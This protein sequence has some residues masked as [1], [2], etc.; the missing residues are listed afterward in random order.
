MYYLSLFSVYQK[1]FVGVSIVENLKKKVNKYYKRLINCFL[2]LL[3]LLVI[4]PICGGMLEDLKDSSTDELIIFAISYGAILMLC[5][6]PAILI[7]RTVRRGKYTA[8][9]DEY[10]NSLDAVGKARLENELQQDY[11]LE[12]AALTGDC[13]VVINKGNLAVAP[14]QDIVWIYTN[15]FILFRCLEQRYLVLMTRQKRMVNILLSKKDTAASI[16][17]F[18]RSIKEKRPGVLLGYQQPWISLFNQDFEKM[19]D[20]SDRSATAERA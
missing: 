12:H 1:Y 6:V 17:N 9:F 3:V 16:D 20:Q 15:S 14:Y 4:F 8:P 13:V 7:S 11:P 10:Y 5:I 18:I 19:V 2:I